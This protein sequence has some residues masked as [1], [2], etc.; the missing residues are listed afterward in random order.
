[1]IPSFWSSSVSL[2]EESFW[3]ANGKI[4]QLNRK[5]LLSGPVQC[6]WFCKDGPFPL[7]FAGDSSSSASS[8]ASQISSRRNGLDIA[9]YW[10]DVDVVDVVM[11]RTSVYEWYTY[12]LIMQKCTPNFTYKERLSCSLEG[13][14]GWGTIT[15]NLTCRKQNQSLNE[16]AFWEGN[17]TLVPGLKQS[18]WH[19][20]HLLPQKGNHSWSTQL[21]IVVRGE[22]VRTPK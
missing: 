12:N 7:D 22:R 2:T 16:K 18:I 20:C 5:T 15:C 9:G 4:G 1:M 19:S 11:K 3:N 8:S 21:L 13:Q 17:L 10:F 6:H 14:K